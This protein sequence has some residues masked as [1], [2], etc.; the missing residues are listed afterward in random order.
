MSE[1]TNNSSIKAKYEDQ[2]FVVIPGLIPPEDWVDLEAACQ[3]V[4]QKTRDGS[5]PH[6]RVVGKQFP[7]FGDHNPDSWGVQHVMH[8]QLNESA[9]AKWYTSDRLLDV[10]KELLG[11]KDEEL[12][13]GKFL[14]FS[15]LKSVAHI[16]ARI[17]QFT[18]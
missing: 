8:P 17:I 13:L 16:L 9:F 10:V 1:M 11:C 15:T 14:F 18:H 3:R 12:Q 6:R 2:G 5:W 4:I 7:P